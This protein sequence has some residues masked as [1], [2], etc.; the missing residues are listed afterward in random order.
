M[1]I[2]RIGRE[3]VVYFA[4]VF[5]INALVT[6]FYNAFFHGTSVVDWESS[7]RFAIIFGVVFPVAGQLE[8][9]KI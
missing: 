3:F 2:K 1:N 8:R 9:K 6:F 5:V 7:L 4:L